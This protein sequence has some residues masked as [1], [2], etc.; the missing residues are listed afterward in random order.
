MAILPKKDNNDSV[1]KSREKSINK[2]Q[3]KK[4]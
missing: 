1:E 4:T 2:S 3:V